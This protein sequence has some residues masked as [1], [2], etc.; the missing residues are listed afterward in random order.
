MTR[1]TLGLRWSRGA[2]VP[3]PVDIA[4]GHHSGARDYA[5][6]ISGGR[7]VR[8][9]DAVSLIEHELGLPVPLAAFRSTAVE[10]DR[11]CADLALASAH[12]GYSPN[13]AL[14]DGLRA[15]IGSRR[16]PAGS[17]WRSARRHGWN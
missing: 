3:L 15:Q 1:T 7:S 4:E 8:L 5:Y 13:T 12:L 6:N 11:T 2:T 16:P 14:R 17:P 9:S 10:A